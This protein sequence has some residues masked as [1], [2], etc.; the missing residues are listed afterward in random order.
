MST[1]ER[2]RTTTNEAEKE[3]H[4]GCQKNLKKKFTELSMSI[5]KVV[6]RNLRTATDHEFY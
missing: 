6:F 4:F 3:N 2:N 1:E 5:I